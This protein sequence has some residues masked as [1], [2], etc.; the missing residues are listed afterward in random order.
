MERV[1]VGVGGRQRDRDNVSTWWSHS[2]HVCTLAGCMKQ[3]TPHHLPLT[4]I[5]EVHLSEDL[6]CPFLRRGLILWHFHHG[7]HHL[8]DCLRQQ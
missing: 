4:I 1:G 3:T 6:V 7:G 2:V 8:V 5:V